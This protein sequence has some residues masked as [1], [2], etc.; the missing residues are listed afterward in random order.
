MTGM[1]W[2]I[3]IQ[4]SFPVTSKFGNIDN[5]MLIKF[6]LNFKTTYSYWFNKGMFGTVWPVVGPGFPSGGRLM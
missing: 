4:S 2:L 6:D 1:K 3:Q 5:F